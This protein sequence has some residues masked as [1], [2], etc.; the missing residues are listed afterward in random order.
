MTKKE[1]FV[2]VNDTWSNTRQY[3]YFP[4]DEIGTSLFSRWDFGITK[5]KK[6]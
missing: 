3:S 4:E 5:V 6:K 2:I 1:Q